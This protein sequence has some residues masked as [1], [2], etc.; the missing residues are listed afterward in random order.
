MELRLIVSL[1][2]VYA[3]TIWS[4]DV[5]WYQK[6]ICRSRN[7]SFSINAR[8]LSEWSIR[9]VGSSKFWKIESQ[10]SCN[11]IIP[12]IPSHNRGGSYLEVERYWNDRREY[13]TCGAKIGNRTSTGFSE[14]T[15]FALWLG[16]RYAVVD[17]QLELHE[18]QLR[19]KARAR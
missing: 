13:V 17:Y 4:L 2:E 12:S 14:P 3:Q 15:T 11:G 10:R 6:N 1:K 16:Y 8:E 7:P 18:S 5:Y 19:A 9:L